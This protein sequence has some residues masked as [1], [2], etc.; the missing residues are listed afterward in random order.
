MQYPS[1]QLA[2]SISAITTQGVHAL[3]QAE[4]TGH[5]CPVGQELLLGRLAAGPFQP[6][7]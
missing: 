5:R 1:L 2:R 6:A 7:P 4:I 3:E